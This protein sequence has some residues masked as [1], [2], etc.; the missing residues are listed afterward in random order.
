M[1][2]PSWVLHSRRK[3]S[4]LLKY[5]CQ[6]F[7]LPQLLARL[8]DS[9]R[10]PRIPTFDVVNSLFHTAL[11]RIPSIN[12]LEGDLKESDFQALLGKAASPDVKLF[13]AEVVSNVL[14]KLDVSRIRQAMLEVF[15]KAERNKAFRDQT[16][17]ALRCVAVDG[18]EA[19]TSY[20]RHCPD[21]LERQ[22]VVEEETVTQYYHRYVVALF[23]G[24]LLDVV[25]DIEP[26]RNKAARIRAGESNVDEDE[27]EQ[28]AALRLLDRLHQTYGTI[29]DAISFD[30][31]Y[32][33]GPVLNKV[34]QCGYGAF[35]IVKKKHNQPLKEALALW[36]GQPPCRVVHDPNS[37]EDIEFWDTDPMEVLDTYKGPI[38][39]IRARVTQP[40]G[41]KKKRTW[42]IA[43]VGKR[44]MR[45]PLTAILKAARARW[46]IENTAFH[47]W[48]MYWNLNHVFRHTANATL[49][50][51]LLWSLAFNL[52]QFFVYR[53]LKRQRN[54][55]DPTDTIRH[56]VEVINREIAT[57]VEPIPW[58]ALLDTS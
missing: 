51:L 12:A 53:R 16:Y 25:L 6:V 47:Q 19:F 27:G 41:K 14:D 23:I 1:A 18:W 58:A 30:S 26:I 4:Q 39:V 24:P 38:R 56:I 35:I 34:A 36:R 10:E 40:R 50:V 33:N 48:V 42:C 29:I 3:L 45:A 8:K 54:P 37:G 49:A 5:G 15:N 31:L 44:A 22:V 57:L 21:C 17:G 55:K 11:L 43:V 20:H 7:R 2:L 13:S 28:T 46:H 52:L 32:P 9:R